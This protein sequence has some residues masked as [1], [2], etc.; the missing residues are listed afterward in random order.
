MGGAIDWLPRHLYK[1]VSGIMNT[2]PINMIQSL[3]EWTEMGSDSGLDPLAMARPSEIIYQNLLPGISTITVRMRYYSFLS[4][5]V[6]TYAADIGNTNPDEFFKFQRNAEALYALIGVYDSY[7]T[8]LAGAIWASRIL[9][10]NK[11]EIIDFAKSAQQKNGGLLQ[12][13]KGALGGIYGTQ[14]QEMNLI[15]S[16]AEHEIK[17]PTERGKSL[18]KAFEETLGS[19]TNIFKA[20]ILEG[21]ISRTNLKKL[22]ILKPSE[23]NANTEEGKLLM[24]I[25]LGSTKNPSSSD[26]YRRDSLLRILNYA[27]STKSIPVDHKVRWSWFHSL[28]EQP[29]LDPWLVYHVNDLLILG[30]ETLLKRSLE[31][32]RGQPDSSV[33]LL[34]LPKLVFETQFDSEV[35][36]PFL[37]SVKLNGSEEELANTIMKLGGKT[38]MLSD[39]AVAAAITLIQNI[40]SWANMHDQEIGNFFTASSAFQSINTELKFVQ[41]LNDATVNEV[42][43][44]ILTERILKRHLWV[45][46]QKFRNQPFKYTFLFEFDEG[47][48]RFRHASD[49]QLGYPRISQAIQFLED[50]KLLDKDEGISEYGDAVLSA[51]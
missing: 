19:L 29:D 27:K 3:P 26:L 23:I 11:A 6:N 2:I 37:K 45:A 14:L 40:L 20:A 17:I 44:K 13:R 46:S 31:I 22:E 34:E 38:A 21:K 28:R 24:D 1:G 15:T 12:N 7:N 50:I 8:G 36:E 25:L 16:S 51:L 41:S 32:M 10:E 18:A 35:K 4:W 5:V 42:L 47:M 30:Y 48:L 43:S 39:E 9:F 33:G 49:A